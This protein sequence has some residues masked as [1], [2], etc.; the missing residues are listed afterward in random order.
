MNARVFEILPGLNTVNLKKNQCID[1]LFNSPGDLLILSK[2]VAEG[3]VF[4]EDDGLKFNKLFDISC[5]DTTQVL[6]YGGNKTKHGQWPFLA[7]ILEKSPLKFFCGGNVITNKH[8]LTAAHCVEA[9]KSTK[10]RPADIIV[11]LGRH[12][13]SSNSEGK[14]VT[15]N[16]E[17]I[18]IHPDWIAKNKKYDADLAILSLEEKVDFS[19]FIRPVCLTDD[20]KIAEYE[21]G[22]VVGWGNSPKA[23]LEDT[24]SQILIHSIS[25]SNCLQNDWHLGIIYSNRSFCAGGRGSAPCKGDSGKI[26]VKL[27][28]LTKNENYCILQAVDFSLNLVAFGLCEAWSQLD[29]GT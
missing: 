17:K 22:Y 21:D 25:D 15:R 11:Y 27:E 24:P 8:V 2:V 7:G 29:Q 1:K 16:V 23:E 20:T 28:N 19:D 14:S 13:L 26:S 18:S 12:S 5:G 10:R 4:N 6:I 3:C 9:K